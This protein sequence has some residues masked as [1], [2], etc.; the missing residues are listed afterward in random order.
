MNKKLLKKIGL[1][2]ALVALS[3][4][5]LNA[6][7]TIINENFG[8]A[9][10]SSASDPTDLNT[11]LVSGTPIWIT[12]HNTNT[13]KW[14]IDNPNSNVWTGAN[15]TWAVHNT[16]IKAA[17]NDKISI[18]SDLEFGGVA[19][20]DAK[21]ICIVG[22]ATTKVLADIKTSIGSKRDGVLLVPTGGN[23][24]AQGSGSTFPTNPSIIQGAI[25]GPYEI[26]IEYTVGTDATNTVKKVRIKNKNSGVQSAIGEVTG[27]NADVYAALTGAGA[28]FI[29]W[30]Q[31]FYDVNGLTKIKISKLNVVKNP[32]TTLGIKDFNKASIA[33]SVSPNPVSSV[34]TVSQNVVTKS[35]KV[36]NLAGTTVL[37][38][39]A[40]GSI[41]VSNLANGVY[42]LVTDSGITK[43]I[44]N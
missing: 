43:F 26:T 33:V 10:Y 35:Y 29:N 42:L 9:S 5:Q 20:L 38:T 23:L 21:N 39:A 25:T 37:E 32:T 1:F 44:K 31:T 11:A 24:V 34:L 28:Y 13:N 17:I 2:V 18:T 19:F 4:T 27:I 12:G 8:G 41:D 40:T 36:V 16:V 3:C 30:S 7:T 15:F 6:Q 22:L 14:Q